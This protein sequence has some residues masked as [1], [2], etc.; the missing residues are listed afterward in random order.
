MDCHGQERAPP[1]RRHAP[2]LT[3]HWA[4][5]ITECYRSPDIGA[6]Q[7]SFLLGRS[8]RRL[9]PSPCALRQRHL[10]GDMSIH[11]L[12]GLL[13]MR[14]DVRCQFKQ[15]SHNSH[16]KHE[17]VTLVSLKLNPEAVMEPAHLSN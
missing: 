5:V 6:G 11:R 1:R 4:A 3:R 16:A 13:G 8:H 15:R 2:A 12:N 10:D 14:C 7:T 9:G 17:L